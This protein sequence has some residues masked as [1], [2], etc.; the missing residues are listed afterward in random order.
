MDA[1]RAVFRLTRLDKVLPLHESVE[2]AAAAAG[3]K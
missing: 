2:E 3:A 1:V